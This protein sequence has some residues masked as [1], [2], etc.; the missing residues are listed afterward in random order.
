MDF[1]H[2]AQLFN[3]RFDMHVY[4]ITVITNSSM[5]IQITQWFV[6]PRFEAFTAFA[7]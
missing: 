6:D 5:Q 7:F 1:K 4:Y 2:K 3:W